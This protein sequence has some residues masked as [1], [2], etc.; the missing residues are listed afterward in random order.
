MPRRPTNRRIRAAFGATAALAAGITL[1]WWFT[2]P[3]APPPSVSA[4]PT[5][6]A[7]P[8]PPATART[9]DTFPPYNL[10]PLQNPSSQEL[11]A[12]EAWLAGATCDEVCA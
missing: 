5:A 8:P 9:T 12:F 3:P 7:K 11:A 2:P 10:R 1:G 4:A 6:P